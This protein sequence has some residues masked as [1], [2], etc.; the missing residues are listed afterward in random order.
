MTDSVEMW[1]ITGV[2]TIVCGIG[3]GEQKALAA[4]HQG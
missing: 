4:R 3:A 2:N 1:N